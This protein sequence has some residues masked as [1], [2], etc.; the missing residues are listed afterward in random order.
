M[1]WWPRRGSPGSRRKPGRDTVGSPPHQP[2]IAITPETMSDDAHLAR[3][4]RMTRYPAPRRGRPA[5]GPRPPARALHRPAPGRRGAPALASPP[6][7]RR[8]RDAAARAVSA[9]HRGVHRSRGPAAR[10]RGAIGG[11]PGAGH[12]REVLERV[13]GAGPSVVDDRD[14]WPSRRRLEGDRSPWQVT[15]AGWVTRRVLD[16][17]PGLGGAGPP[18]NRIAPRA[19]A[20]RRGSSPPGT[21]TGHDAGKDTVQGAQ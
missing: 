12:A 4:R 10:V 21:P 19:N 9:C 6:G 11:G 7:R 2:K 15:A 20:T 17:S 1:G 18:A 14:G 13:A 3:H 8:S 16:A 5:P